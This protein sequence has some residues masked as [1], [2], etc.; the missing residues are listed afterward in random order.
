[1]STVSLLDVNVLI[2]MTW[3]SHEAHGKV[4]RW[5]SQKGHEPWS[6]CPITQT[7]F[8]RILCNPGFSRHALTATDANTLLQSNLKHPGHQFWED[9]IPLHDALHLVEGKLAGHQQVTDAYLL[10]LAIH[11]K[12]RLVTL[13]RR[14]SA[15]LP[16]KATA[17]DKLT[18]L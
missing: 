14:L 10:G 8:V 15:L 5:L 16:A 13:D 3:P 7:S 4:Q 6:S 11:K 17:G 18:V 1:M 12:G 9:G 2:A